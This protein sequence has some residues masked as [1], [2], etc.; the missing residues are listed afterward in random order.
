MQAWKTK[1]R[2]DG[3]KFPSDEDNAEARRAGQLALA[4]SLN[5]MVQA[6]KGGGQ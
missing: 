3:F 2:R 1:M 6:L 5:D 4:A